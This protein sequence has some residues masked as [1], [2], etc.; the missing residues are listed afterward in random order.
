MAAGVRRAAAGGRETA[1][2]GV[3]ACMRTL[4]MLANALVRTGQPWD[5]ARATS[6]TPPA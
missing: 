6:T 2:S 5:S 4:L 1:E 3:T